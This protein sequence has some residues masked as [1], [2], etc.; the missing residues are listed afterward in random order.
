MTNL[1]AVA[2]K[3]E[4]TQLAHPFQ[5]QFNLEQIELIKRTIIPQGCS[6]DELQLFLTQCRRTQLDPFARQIYA[7]KRKG[8]L[9]IETSI[10]GFRLIAE[11][12]GKYAGQL[13]PY[14]CG[15]DGNWK[16]VWLAQEP[17][18][19]AKVGVIRSDFQEPLWAVARFDTYAQ[20]TNEGNLWPNWQKMSDLMSA[21]CA[22]GLALRKAFPQELSGLYSAEEM[23]QVDNPGSYRHPSV[24]PFPNV[25]DFAAL[26]KRVEE[27]GCDMAAYA[28]YLQS[29]KAAGTPA[30]DVY[31]RAQDLFLGD[32]Q[33]EPI[34]TTDELDEGFIDAISGED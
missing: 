6:N 11:R 24:K 29:E 31:G 4:S 27:A 10:D 16:D 26:R 3:E 34:S 25:G 30:I 2:E 22:E 5:L 18:R 12:T 14:W 17:P 9:S 15:K 32:K 1:P 7:I 8:K 28:K 33:D 19:A 13:G 20:V 21:K 23:A